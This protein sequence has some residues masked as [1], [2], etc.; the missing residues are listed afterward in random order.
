MAFLKQFTNSLSLSLWITTR[1]KSP[2]RKEERKENR[3]PTCIFSFETCP[4]PPPCTL[5]HLPHP[6]PLACLASPFLTSRAISKHT[7]LHRCRQRRQRIE[8]S[9]WRKVLDTLAH[10]GTS[11]I[12]TGGRRGINGVC[13]LDK[14]ARWKGAPPRE[15]ASL[16]RVRVYVGGNCGEEA[17]RKQ[18]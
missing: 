16:L 8:P 3:S 2:P 15:L 4:S 9:K 10:K 12:S 14:V 11:E 1:L 13:A 5:H 6:S 18:K 7:C 17:S